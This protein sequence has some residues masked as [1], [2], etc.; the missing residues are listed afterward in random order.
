M[1]LLEQLALEQSAIEGLAEGPPGVSVLQAST[2]LI[3]RGAHCEL[4]ALRRGDRRTAEQLS[5]LNRTS[6]A[7]HKRYIAKIEHSTA[8]L[9]NQRMNAIKTMSVV[10]TLALPVWQL[11]QLFQ[12]NV[13]LPL[14]KQSNKDML[15]V[16][17]IILVAVA[18]LAA[19][20]IYK[21]NTLS[22]DNA[23]S[24]GYRKSS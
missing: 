7:L 24:K 5:E 16:A 14:E 4:E 12:M 2:A 9:R 15:I 18:I 19:T 8:A 13:P 10:F 3:K 21:H 11:A 22:K 1:S 17:A 6:R 23:A 20:L